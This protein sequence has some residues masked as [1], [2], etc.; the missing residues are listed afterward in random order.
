MKTSEAGLAM[1][2]RLEGEVLHVYKDPVGIPTIGVGH[3]VRS[4]E[5]FPQGIT[6]EES[7]E[8][9]RGDVV[10]AERAVNEGVKVVLTQEQFDALVSFVFNVGTGAFKRSTL[11]RLLNQRDYQGAADQFP[12]WRMAGGKVLQGLV[13]RRATERQAFMR[14]PDPVIT[15]GCSGSTGHG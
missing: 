9:L 14:T 12:K 5:S 2:T 4:G 6:E 11:L 10:I 7:R 15:Q 13:N 3:V 1:I 8:L